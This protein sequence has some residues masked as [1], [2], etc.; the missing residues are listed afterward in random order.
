MVEEGS[1]DRP[2]LYGVSLTVDEPLEDVADRWHLA[3]H[4]VTGPRDAIQP[5]R[6]IL[7]VPSASA[8]LA[9]MT[10]RV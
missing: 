8:G 9:V 3:G 1:V 5:G 4:R 6:R 10:P 7:T 2:L